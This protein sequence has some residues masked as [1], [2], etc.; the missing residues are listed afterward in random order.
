MLQWIKVSAVRNPIAIYLH[1]FIPVRYGRVCRTIIDL[2]TLPIGILYALF[3]MMRSWLSQ[4]QPEGAHSQP[5]LAIVAIIKNEK[6]NI[7]EWIEYHK[8]IGVTK[9]YIYDNE[10]TDEVLTVLDKYIE[11]GA[12]EYIPISGIMRQC[13]AYNDALNR[14]GTRNYLLTV[15]DLDEFV[16]PQQ[17]S[18][19][20][21][22]SEA[23]NDPRVSCLCVNWCIFGS[24]GY[25][26]RPAGLVIENYIHR[27]TVNNPINHHVK[28]ICVPAKT[29]GFLNPHFAI[30]I[31]G[32]HA[33]DPA[34]HQVLGAQNVHVDHSRI[35]INHYF[36]KSYSEFIEKRSRGKADDIAKRSLSEFEE[37]DLNDVFD[38]SAASYAR[39]IHEHLD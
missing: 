6:R 32:Y 14:I 21:I 37:H 38:D 8:L 9:F 30:S 11:E 18:L 26:E 16:F 13:D 4:F 1:R 24:S 34:G 22:L 33:V 29:A 27:G 20:D 28:S 31:P 19:I 3:L 23:F 15:I 36:T 25:L 2:S 17:E 12:V 35:R 7:T 10:S 5:Q 39:Q